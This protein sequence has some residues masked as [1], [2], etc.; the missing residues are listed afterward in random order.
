[1]RRENPEDNKY[2]IQRCQLEK[3]F[4][5]ILGFTIPSHLLDDEDPLKSLQDLI[6]AENKDL[7]DQL[8]TAL[9]E[10]KKVDDQKT[11]TDFFRKD[12]SEI[13]S[14]KGYKTIYSV[15]EDQEHMSQVERI[16]RYRD[17][18]LERNGGLPYILPEEEHKKHQREGILPNN[19]AQQNAVYH[20][21]PTQ[22][23]FDKKEDKVV[24]Q[25]VQ[26]EVQAPEPIN[27]GAGLSSNKQRSTTSGQDKVGSGRKVTN[28]ND[29]NPNEAIKFSSRSDMEDTFCV[30]KRKNDNQLYMQCEGKCEWYHPKCVG[31][32]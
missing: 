27:T 16:F 1:M 17:K 18:Q 29:R 31:F 3:K 23:K 10:S 13:G 15:D 26:M 8:Q 28:K 9:N 22:P 14:Y 30:C 24:P 5:Q 11:Y 21:P 25:D 6:P 4:S 12:I 2:V 32:D 7:L 20:A 19:N